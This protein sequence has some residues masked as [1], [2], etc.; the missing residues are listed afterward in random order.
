M[1]YI[2]TYNIFEKLDFDEFKNNI[3]EL[4]YPLSDAGY[5]VRI[6]NT[7]SSENYD[8]TIRVV[9]YT[10]EFL[11]INEFIDDFDTMYDYAKSEGFDIVVRYVIE[12][13]SHQNVESYKFFR[14]FIDRKG[15]LYVR[16]LNFSVIKNNK[17]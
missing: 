7:L 8:I 2:K 11:C 12:E 1:R 9:E 14:E 15:K 3:Q 13:E 17:I 5:D 6:F 10:D 16:N 4:L